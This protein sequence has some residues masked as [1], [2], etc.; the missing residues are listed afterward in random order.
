MRES[1]ASLETTLLCKDPTFK[2]K[3]ILNFIPLIF[4][5]GRSIMHNS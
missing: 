5:I 4:Q 1:P 2:V 3:I